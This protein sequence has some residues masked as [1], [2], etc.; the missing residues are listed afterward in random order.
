[1]LKR[2]AIFGLLVSN[3][4]GSAQNPIQLNGGR[5]QEHPQ[6]RPDTSHPNPQTVPPESA[7][8]QGGGAQQK[9]PDQPRPKGYWEEAFAPANASNWVLAL[10]G[11]V[12]GIMAGITLAFIAGQTKILK[13]S[14]AV[15]QKAADAADISAK[16]AMG[17]SVPLV[18]LAK[19][20]FVVTRG[21]FHPA[22]FYERPHAKVMLKNY[23]QSPAILKQYGVAFDLDSGPAKF[24]D[25][26]FDAE[27][28]IDP[29]GTFI[30]DES[31]L[32]D[33]LAPEA[34]DRLVNGRSKLTFSFWV[35]YRDVF[36]S[37]LKK[38]G[39]DKYLVEYDSDP[40]K[41]AIADFEN[42]D[43]GDDAT[44]ASQNNEQPSR[45]N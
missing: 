21:K 25:Y 26:Y 31:T 33:I 17:I 20:S 3:V 16:A 36:G 13:D 23:G 30:I 35:T 5:Q 40:S 42:V 6:A 2:L 45:A 15:A 22:E 12:G 41:M 7:Q 29:G 8:K 38:F 18:V 11:A 44:G 37:P 24:R 14:V 1:M 43:L 32:S 39:F 19:F 34:V 28:I 27:E 4:L 10:L 9:T